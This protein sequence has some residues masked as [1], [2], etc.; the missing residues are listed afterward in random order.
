V[1]RVYGL[2]RNPRR[3]FPAYAPVVLWHRLTHR[4]FGPPMGCSCMRCFR[5]VWRIE[6]PAR[7]GYADRLR[8]ARL[9]RAVRDAGIEVPFR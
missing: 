9:E 2:S 8:L 3:H 5:S 4:L 6:Y 7:D 1:T